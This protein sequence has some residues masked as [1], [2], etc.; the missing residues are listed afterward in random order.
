MQLK[1]LQ[2]KR[3]GRLTV[4]ERVENGGTNIRY[5]RRCDCGNETIVFASS[6]R[7]GNTCSCG[8]L[9]NEYIQMM[10]KVSESLH[11]EVRDN[12]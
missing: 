8:C 2:G 11:S 5:R 7:N 3:Y 6:L 12:N 4:L 9:R 10:K 1:N